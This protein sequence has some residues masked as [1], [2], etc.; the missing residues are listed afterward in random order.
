MF[1][2]CSHQ[3]KEAAKVLGVGAPVLQADPLLMQENKKRDLNKRIPENDPLLLKGKDFKKR[4]EDPLQKIERPT[5]GS[6]KRGQV[7]ILR[8]VEDL[9]GVKS[10]NKDLGKTHPAK[11]PERNLIL[12]SQLHLKQQQQQPTFLASLGGESLPKSSSA[13]SVK[14]PPLGKAKK[15]QLLAPE[16]S[17]TR[18]KQL[19]LSLKSKRIKEEPD[20]VAISLFSE[21][22]FNQLLLSEK[23]CKPASL[24]SIAVSLFVYDLV[25]FDKY[26]LVSNG[27]TSFAVLITF[28]SKHRSLCTSYTH[29]KV[30]RSWIPG[31]LRFETKW[32]YN[33]QLI[34]IYIISKREIFHVYS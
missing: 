19:P 9:A 12:G 4:V 24:D 14:S 31:A 7:S 26:C 33:N 17:E 34:L 18:K 15:T 21:D 13:T 22:K 27:Y 8:N 32:S 5:L 23:L 25:E 11:N 30:S 2:Q 6:N 1:P 29:F 16:V 10:A 28:G 3:V 20:V